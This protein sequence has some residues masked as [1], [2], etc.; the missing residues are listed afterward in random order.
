MPTYTVDASVFLNAFNPYEEG[1]E[2]SRRLLELLQQRAYPLAEPVLLLPEL[3]ATVARGRHDAS[4]ALAFAGAV[5]RLPHMILVAIDSGLGWQAAEIASG[6]RLRASDAL[7]VAVAS[8]FGATLVTLDRE[9]L[10]R[11]R[12]IVSVCLPA[13][14]LSQGM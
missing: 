14:A 13:D 3:A 1:H 8:R 12:T 2:E 6:A 4:L 9:Q 11:A 10:E 5:S 7:Y